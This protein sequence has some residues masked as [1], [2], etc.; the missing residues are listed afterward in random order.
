M[1]NDHKGRMSHDNYGTETFYASGQGGLEERADGKGGSMQ[2]GYYCIHHSGR[3]G[4]HTTRK[5]ALTA[6]RRGDH[7]SALIATCPLINA[8]YQADPH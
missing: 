5:K 4:P 7:E 3:Y 6:A 1:K 8:A 2:R